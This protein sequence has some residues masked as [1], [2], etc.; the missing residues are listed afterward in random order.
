MP[1]HADKR[2]LKVPTLE[3]PYWRADDAQEVLTLW[4]RSGTSL[5]GFAR[6]YGLCP[7]RLARWRDRLQSE[8]PVP[9]FHPVRLV[10]AAGTRPLSDRTGGEIEIVLGG[11][12]RVVVR[13]G[14]DPA[15]LAEV[16]RVLETIAC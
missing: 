9:R 14:F 3:K 15:V 7:N 12:R 4:R 1:R 10:E 16:V 6:E 13:P 5:A 2:F 8:P 11:A